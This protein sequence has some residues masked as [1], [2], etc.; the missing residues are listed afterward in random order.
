M[1]KL[2]QLKL[3]VHSGKDGL[4]ALIAKTMK[5]EEKEI[6]SYTIRRESL[7]ARKGRQAFWVYNV[8]VEIKEETQFLRVH[9]F[10]EKAVPYVYDIPMVESASR[11]IVVGFGPAGMFASWVMAKAGL[12][13]I[14]IERGEDVDARTR[15]VDA[16][17]KNGSLNTNSNVQ[18]GE[19]GAGTFSDGKLTTRIKDKRI[20]V[21]VDQLIRFGAPKDIAYKQK[22]HVGTDV[23][24]N[25][26]KNMRQEIIDLG[27]EIKFNTTVELLIVEGGK[28]TG[29]VAN[30][31]NI[32]SDHVVLAVGHSA[33]DTFT[34]LH[35]QGVEMEAKP[36]AVGIRIEHPQAMIDNVQYRNV[37][38]E[39]RDGASEYKL[40]HQCQN[41]RSLY[42][43]CMCPGG[44]VVASASEDNGLVVNGMSEHARDQVNA[45]SALV[46]NVSPED[47]GTEPLDGITFQRNLEKKAFELGGGDFT[48]PT[49]LVGDLLG[50]KVDACDVVAS[51]QPQVKK[52]DFNELFPEYVM[53][54]LRE[55]LVA[56]DRKIP[57]F[58]RPD[59]VM[60][61][62][63][64]RTSSP[65]RLLRDRESF[66]SVSI[67]GLY[68]CGEG[69]GYAGGITSSAVDGIKVAEAI[70]EGLKK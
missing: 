36:F 20:N 49:M 37:P 45:N 7:D 66:E 62:V 46:V 69:A 15:T 10:F 26:V 25:V 31:E 50:H 51:Y 14:I 67:A 30:G 4:K 65:V 9:K 52:C 48:A 38:K 47:F 60:T 2:T 19:G 29:V 68:P 8:D 34:T 13:P 24:K 12:K 61:A 43:F 23:L 3:P 53:E 59:A 44:M 40:T 16:F 5:I 11:P 18:F 6:V 17:W 33:R 1:I 22:P 42:S 39:A 21:V 41:G 63:E 35:N 57:G 27:G 70:L 28:T 32:M 55:G 58:A 56:F 54:A 64:S